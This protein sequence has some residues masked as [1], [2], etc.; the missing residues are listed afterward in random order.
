[1][2]K[3]ILLGIGLIAGSLEFSPIAW[4]EIQP[5]VGPP[6]TTVTLRGGEFGEFQG[7]HVSRVEFNGVP[8]L[9]QLWERDL[10]LAKVPLH[11]QDG[12][13]Q[14]FVNS[15]ELLSMG[16][17]L[18]T[19]PKITRVNPFQAEPG[20][21][22]I[23]EGEQFGNTAGSQDPNAMFGANHVLINDLR[24][25]VR[26]WQPNK[27][28]VTIPA[29]ATSGPVEVR[30]A[31]MDPLPDG[32]CC[33]PATYT[34]SNAMPVTVIPPI[35]V[36]PT[37]GPVGSKVV[38]SGQDLGDTK[39]QGDAIFF[40]GHPATIA[41]WSPRT[42]V[43]HVPLNA[44]SGPLVLK[45]GDKERSIGHFLVQ[46]S[47]V[48][49]VTPR[50]GPIGTLLRI[51]GA[52]FGV[53]SESGA[54]PYFMD[55]SLGD[56][57]VEIGGVPAI[58]HRWNDD[59]IDVWVPF[60]VKSGPIVVKRGGTV[61]NQD[62]TCCDQRGV[63]ATTAGSF[64]VVTPKIDSYFPIAAGLDEVVTIKGSGFG[65]FLKI[66]EATQAGLLRDAHDSK[67]YQLGQNV[68]RTQVLINDIAVQVVAWTD[69][70]IQVKVPR[71]PIFGIGHPEGFNTNLAKGN[72]VVRRG[73]WDTLSDGTCCGPKQWLSLV[74]G[75]FTILLRGL[76]NQDLFTE[77]NPHRGDAF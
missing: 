14:V 6:G 50:E 9:I 41:S 39:S 21:L 61:P 34:V 5:S 64:S 75:D 31:S 2:R 7:T 57:A 26:T 24:A 73:S 30:L 48:T 18:V 40:N 33:A 77:P 71:R 65:E 15:K 69:T 4:A 28:E 67:A 38:L 1:M 29:N 53:Y 20:A 35:T 44:T 37:E 74:A 68:S 25:A 27:I 52:H 19:Q 3:G 12:L 58:I 22:L 43:V 63:V 60:S 51:K 47:Q 42:I 62:G 36:Q 32:S 10:I 76:P 45:R 59:R 8:A 54:T 17:F 66:S 49:E 55:F 72:V 11:A 56:N 13:V 46:T 23:I 16:T 70:E